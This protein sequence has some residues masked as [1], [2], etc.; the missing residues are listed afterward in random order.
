MF[1]VTSWTF[2]WRKSFVGIISCNAGNTSIGCGGI[3]C[4]GGTCSILLRGWRVGLNACSISWCVVLRFTVLS[5]SSAYVLTLGVKSQPSSQRPANWSL[6]ST[7]DAL[8]ARSLPSASSGQPAP[9]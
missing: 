9:E 2:E 4:S 8:A 1:I 7:P 3:K 6:D 5:S